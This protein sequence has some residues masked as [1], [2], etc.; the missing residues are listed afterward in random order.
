MR[1]HTS[2]ER[3]SQ[4]RQAQLLVKQVEQRVEQDVRTSWQRFDRAQAA[5]S[6]VDK[7]LE[8]ARE[9][10]RLSELGFA[11]GTATWLDVENARASL[12]GSELAH[13][14]ERMQRD[15]AAIS[16]LLAV[17]DL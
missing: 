16:L 3:A 13:I 9:Y 17:G 15:L 5:L 12:A 11:A 4:V 7:E 8:L 6:S 1:I 2:R 10:L 14:Q